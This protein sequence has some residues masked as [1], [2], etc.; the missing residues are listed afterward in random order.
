MLASKNEAAAS[1]TARWL[2]RHEQR[3]RS[4][5][6]TVSVISGPLERS[7]QYLEQ[8][9]HGQERSLVWFEGDCSQPERV[10]YVW[11]ERVAAQY[12]LAD[13]ATRWLA[14]RIDQSEEVLTQSFRDTTPIELAMFLDRA[15]PLSSATGVEAACRW[16]L[17]QAV[18]GALRVGAGKELA[19]G[20]DSALME[21]PRPWLR[22]LVAL[23]ELLTSDRQPI[24]ALRPG[25][26][27][28]EPVAVAWIE[29]AARVLADL[30]MAQ[31]K[32]SLA[33]VVEPASLQT[34]LECAE[35]SRAKSLVRES[36]VVIATSVPESIDH[37]LPANLTEALAEP[38]RSRAQLLE[39]GVSATLVSLFDDAVRAADALDPESCDPDQVDRARSAAE[40]FLYER[41][42]SL[43]ETAGLFRLNQTLGFRFGPSRAIEVDLAATS[44][45]L[46]IEID[47]YYHFQDSDSYRRDRRKDVELQKHGYLVIRV[48]AEDVV[49][50]LEETLKAILAA[51]AFRRH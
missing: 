36:V 48:L 46:A 26:H 29:Q 34:Y 25:K 10:A 28:D 4:G 37:G 16:L 12:D 38:D 31:P 11:V 22:V 23:A 47:G 6:P 24:L 32:L 9:S 15:L 17:L 8:W 40:R 51:V 50:R 42:E 43:P 21:Y 30:A 19:R 44:L 41:L 1:A 7:S 33:L 5:L 13:E 27:T 45:N 20:L 39:S 14:R 35:E 49:C 3:R 18:E 2:D